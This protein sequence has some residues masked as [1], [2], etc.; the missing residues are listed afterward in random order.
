MPKALLQTIIELLSNEEQEK[1]ICWH[2]E[3]NS[4]IWHLKIRNELLEL[5]IYEGD[6]SFGLPIEGKLLNKNTESSQILLKT[7]PRCIPL[8]YQF[9]MH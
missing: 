5:C 4:Y 9:A 7:N 2:G 8:P 6:S 1:W 3:N